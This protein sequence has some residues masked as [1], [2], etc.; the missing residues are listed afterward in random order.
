[1]IQKKEENYI[2]EDN[3]QLQGKFSLVIRKDRI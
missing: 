3:E 1:M 2:S